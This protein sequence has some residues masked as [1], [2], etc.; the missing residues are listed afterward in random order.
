MFLKRSSEAG[1]RK[2]FSAF[3]AKTVNSAMC[4][5]AMPNRQAISFHQEVYSHP[6]LR[7]TIL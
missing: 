6:P 2:I 3:K 7:K 1:G 5:E 4:R